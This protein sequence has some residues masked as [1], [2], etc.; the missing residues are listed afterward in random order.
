M[1]FETAGLMRPFR[2]DDSLSDFSA[3]IE[4]LIDEVDLGHAPVRFDVPHIHLQV[5]TAWTSDQGAFDFMMMRIG[6]HVGS[7]LNAE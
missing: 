2:L 6:W 5:H 7:L 3:A 1:L 4:A